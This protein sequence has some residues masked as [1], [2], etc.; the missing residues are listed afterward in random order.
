M[1]DRKSGQSIGNP[2]PV[3]ID[4]PTPHPTMVPCTVLGCPRMAH[5]DARPGYCKVHG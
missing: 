4:R 3:I 1:T 2:P 5:T